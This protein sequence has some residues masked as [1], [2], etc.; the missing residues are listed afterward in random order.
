MTERKQWGRG[1]DA[2][3]GPSVGTGNEEMGPGAPSRDRGTRP[4][5]QPGAE[6]KLTRRR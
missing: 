1:R 3:T 5:L 6:G 4:A 2:E